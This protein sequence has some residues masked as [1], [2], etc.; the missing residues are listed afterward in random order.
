MNRQRQVIQVVAVALAL[1]VVAACGGDSGGGDSSG[2]VTIYSGRTQN[3]IEPILKRFADETGIDVKVRYGQSADLALLI[4]EEGDK[5]PADLAVDD[6]GLQPFRRLVD[7][8]VASDGDRH[9]GVHRAVTLGEVRV[10]VDVHADVRNAVLFGGTHECPPIGITATVMLSW[11]P[12]LSAKSTRARAAAVASF[13]SQ[14][15]AMSSA[16]GR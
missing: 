6:D 4:N 15:R 11:P 2:S 9:D 13:P 10:V 16:S 3:L 5:T 1:L 14:M 12:A 8:H 7:D